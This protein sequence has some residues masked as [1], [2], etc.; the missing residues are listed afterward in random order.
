MSDPKITP[1][2]AAPKPKRRFRILLG[3]SLALNLLVIG[4]VVGAISKGPHSRGGPPGLREVSAPYVGA[5]ERDQKREMRRDMRAQLPDRSVART[6]NEA[7]YQTFLELVRADTFD[8]VRANEIIE[9]QLERAGQFQRV[10]REL[11]IKRLNEMSDADRRAYADRL[12]QRLEGRKK[13]GKR[14][15]R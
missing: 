4:A 10:G 3:V 5:F 9:K 7:D 14:K 15:E 8:A 2:D 13:Y 6:A 11:S 1:K 12:E